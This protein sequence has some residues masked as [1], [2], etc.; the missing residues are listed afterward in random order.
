[1]ADRLCE[2]DCTQEQRNLAIQS[3]I[4]ASSSFYGL[5]IQNDLN[6]PLAVTQLREASLPFVDHEDQVIRRAAMLGM[7]KLN[8]FE[9]AKDKNLQKFELARNSI[10]AVIESL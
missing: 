5:D 7:A 1:M 4:D 6:L 10:F 2:L 3:R 9:Y 8:V